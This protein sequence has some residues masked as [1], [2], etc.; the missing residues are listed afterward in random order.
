MENILLISLAINFGLAVAVIFFSFKDE[1]KKNLLTNQQRQ[2]SRTLYEVSILNQVSEKIE[3]AR[4]YPSIA[5]TI[6]LTIEQLMEVTTI[7]YAIREDDQVVAKTY[8]DDNVTDSYLKQV[9]HLMRDSMEAIDPDI[10]LLHFKHEITRNDV[11]NHTS[12]PIDTFAGSIFD[13]PLVFHSKYY[14]VI[15]ITHKKPNQYVK[16]DMEVLYK[17]VRQT[18][19]SI[20]RLE[21]VVT[22]EKG[23]LDAL[24]VS[25][26]S[27]AILLTLDNGYLSLSTINHAACD[28]LNVPAT[29]DATRVI[30]SLGTSHDFVRLIKDVMR[31]K[32]SMMLPEVPIKDKF[33][34]IFLNPVFGYDANTIIGVNVTL[35]DVTR[36]KE[37]DQL[38]QTFT[39]M[40]VHELRAP[41]VSIKGASML[42]MGNT[43]PPEEEKKM[44][45]TIKVSVDRMLNQVSDLL[46][47]SKLEAGKF[48]IS[49]SQGNINTVITDRVNVLN[50]DA[51]TRKVHLESHLDSH[52]PDFEF[53]PER[54]GQVVNNLISN[55]LKFTKA[56]GTVTVKSCVEN[57]F[58]AISVSDTG[59]G[60]PD[61]KKALLFSKYSQLESIAKSKGT[62]LGLYISKGIVEAH[63]GKIKLD[64]EVGKGTTVT[65]MIPLHQDKKDVVGKGQSDRGTKEIQV[66]KGNIEVPIQ[67]LPGHPGNVVVN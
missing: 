36:E 4:D 49:L 34:K 57:G 16:A 11:K 17:I 53:D 14:G 50:Y 3:G 62:G 45:G 26:P 37:L 41:L 40:I 66:I 13:I 60:I 32:T 12:R 67:H 43:L 20:E 46:D 22:S 9:D 8:T 29:A 27:G 65:V 33:Y 51:E 23:K 52:M 58:A 7:S 5:Q 47:S 21:E 64:S 2:L 59:V 15:T 48:D 25:L 31:D 42:L 24:V 55:A 30:A 56:G 28:F 39:S 6:A 44:L 61:D 54:M 1:H 10:R 38:K 35:Q 19:W 18:E 63:H